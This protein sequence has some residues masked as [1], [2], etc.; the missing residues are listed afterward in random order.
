MLLTSDTIS[1]YPLISN[2]RKYWVIIRVNKSRSLDIEVTALGP[3]SYYAWVTLI[4]LPI[5]KQYMILQNMLKYYQLI[6]I[7][8]KLKFSKRS[9]INFIQVTSI[10]RAHSKVNSFSQFSH[11]TCYAMKYRSSQMKLYHTGGGI[12]R[13]LYCKNYALF[14]DSCRQNYPSL[15]LS[16]WHSFFWLGL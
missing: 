7:W 5:H 2:Y 8:S 9:D 3:A 16:T 11:L 4:E 12:G 10:Y 6:F 15:I 14:T 1:R 13:L